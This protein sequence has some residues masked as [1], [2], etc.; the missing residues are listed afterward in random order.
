[1]CTIQIAKNHDEES[2]VISSRS[3]SPHHHQ[4][5]EAFWTV[6]PRSPPPLPD[7]L[8]PRLPR[9]RARR[10]V[11]P[12]S[13]MYFCTW[14]FF[15]LGPPAVAD[16]WV[17][18][19]PFHPFDTPPSPS[20][21]PAAAAAATPVLAGPTFKRKVRVC[22]KG[23]ARAEAEEEEAAVNIEAE[24]DGVREKSGSGDFNKTVD[25][26]ELGFRVDEMGVLH[27]SP[28]KMMEFLIA[29]H[30]GNDIAR[31]GFDAFWLQNQVRL[32]SA[33]ELSEYDEVSCSIAS[34]WAF[35]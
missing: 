19:T 9:H 23:R 35:S 14:G 8:P 10:P 20:P 15:P 12:G 11:V 2:L 28:L 29:E 34:Y 3:V 16:D 17:P 27:D 31:S 30:R 32:I 4:K 5:R 7:A 1:M 21:A 18:F 6:L 33:D 22:L 25:P 24:A 26:S 13:D